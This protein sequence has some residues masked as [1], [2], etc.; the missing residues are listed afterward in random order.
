MIENNTLYRFSGATPQEWRWTRVDSVQML[1]V[2]PTTLE[3][4]IPTSGMD[5]SA[6][7]ASALVENWSNWSTLLDSIPRAGAG[8][9]LGW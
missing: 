1:L 3:V 9:Q 8:W 4:H 2:G 6:G 5:L 7:S